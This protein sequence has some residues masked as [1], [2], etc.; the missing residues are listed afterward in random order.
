MSQ[1]D[2]GISGGRT[3]G[4]V[5][6]PAA[7]QTCGSQNFIR[8]SAG[9]AP[10]FDGTFY[11]SWKQKMRVHLNSMSPAIWRIVQNGFVVVNQDLPTPEED[12]LIH[13]NA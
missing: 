13:A 6:P 2:S 9:R 12:K 11:S 8:S 4:N 10:Y 7:Y 3:Y 5:P 1:D